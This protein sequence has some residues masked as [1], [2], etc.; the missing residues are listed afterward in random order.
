MSLRIDLYLFAIS[1][2][3]DRFGHMWLSITAGCG[4]KAL[5]NVT[6]YMLSPSL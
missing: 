6:H 3:P 4:H 5:M 2:V 1:F